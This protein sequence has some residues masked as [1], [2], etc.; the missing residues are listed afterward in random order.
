MLDEVFGAENFRNEIVWHYYN[1]MQGNINRFA[2]NHD[3]IFWYS[4]SAKYKFTRIREERE[5]PKQQQKR[6]WNAKTKS[7]KQA[8]DAEGNLVYSGT[9]EV[10]AVGAARTFDAASSGTGPFRQLR[11]PLRLFRSSCTMA[12]RKWDTSDKERGPDVCRN[13]VERA[14]CCVRSRGERATPHH[15]PLPAAADG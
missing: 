6:V 9:G 12:P 7:L 5:T 11:L 13:A 3:V 14:A 10:G 2:S 15:R 1:K 4:K 8:R